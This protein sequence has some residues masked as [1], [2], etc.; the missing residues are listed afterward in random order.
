MDPARDLRARVR[1]RH[2]L[3]QQRGEWQ[4]RVQAV[5]YHHGLPQRRDLL[6]REHRAWVQR[7]ALPETAR[8][9]VTSRWR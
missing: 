9:Q 7:A 8:E 3:C 4:Q 1:L 6:T 5:L 2:T